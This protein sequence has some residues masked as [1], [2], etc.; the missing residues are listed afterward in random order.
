VQENLGQLKTWKIG[1]VGLSPH[2]SCD[3]SVEFLRRSFPDAYRDIV[4]GQEIVI[5]PS[6][7]PIRG[8]SPG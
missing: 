7:A 2:D 4:V 8:R 3:T 6:D 5:S 1:V